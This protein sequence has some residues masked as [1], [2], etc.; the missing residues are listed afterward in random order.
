MQTSKRLRL[1]VLTVHVGASVGSLG[2]VASFLVLAIL[3]F[4]ATDVDKARSIYLGMDRIALLV[5]LPTISIALLSGVVEG[6]ITR[7]GLFAQ[8]WVRTKLALTAVALIVL[9]AKIPLIGQAA[10]M[11][12]PEA[13]DPEMHFIGLQLLV[14]LAGGLAVLLA[15]LF[16]PSTSPNKNRRPPWHA[17]T[18]SASGDNRTLMLTR[19]TRTR[20]I[21]AGRVLTLAYM[22]AC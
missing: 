12:R 10:R 18:P 20:R 5:V 2:A 21:L 13:L 14:H 19:L 11:P 4:A 17:A 22:L 8:T 16:C 3:G 1:A 7:Y 6:F 9:V 15:A